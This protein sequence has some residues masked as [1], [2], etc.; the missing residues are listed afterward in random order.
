MPAARL[1]RE[2]AT[3]K[4]WM[5]GRPLWPDDSQKAWN[6][7]PD[8]FAWGYGGRGPAQLA[9]AVLLKVTDRT[10]ALRNYQQFKWEVIAVTPTGRF[11][12]RDRHR[13]V[14]DPN[15]R[16]PHEDEVTA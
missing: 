9:L 8:G 11:R 13:K 12:H 4:V 1:R 14:A 3:R 16:R 15:L 10:T 5:D 6:H 2:W 7:S